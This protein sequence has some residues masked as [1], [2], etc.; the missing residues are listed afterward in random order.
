MVK[1]YHSEVVSG[2]WSVVS[3]QWSVVSGQLLKIRQIRGMM[4]SNYGG[5]KEN[6]DD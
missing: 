3:G 6:N 5:R 2:Q 4:D 1:R